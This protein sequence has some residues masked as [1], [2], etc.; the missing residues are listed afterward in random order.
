MDVLVLPG[1]TPLLRARTVAELV[2]EHRHSGAACT[3]LTARLDDPTGYGRIVRVGKDEHVARIVEHRD[4]TTEELEHRR[5]Q[6]GDLLLPPQ[7]PGARPCAWSA[8]TTPRASTTS[9]TSWRCWPR[10]ATAW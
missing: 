6:H 7:P 4:A 5:D 10:P 8:P 2:A 9:P 1:D 3:V